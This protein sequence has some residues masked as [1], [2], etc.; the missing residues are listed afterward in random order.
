MPHRLILGAATFAIWFAYVQATCTFAWYIHVLGCFNSVQISPTVGQIFKKSLN[1][2]D[3]MRCR[4]NVGVGKFFKEIK[5][6]RLEKQKT[7]RVI[8]IYAKIK[9]YLDTCTSHYLKHLACN[10]DHWFFFLLRAYQFPNI[11]NETIPISFLYHS[12]AKT[13]MYAYIF[14][15]GGYVFFLI[16]YFHY[17][18]KPTFCK[19][20]NVLES[21]MDRF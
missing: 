18:F 17:I 8:P 21:L 2:L 16:L 15:W 6:L 13:H 9:I 3:E 20:R 14:F 4:W 5:S 10:A 1:I 7:P 11:L 12:V 19:A